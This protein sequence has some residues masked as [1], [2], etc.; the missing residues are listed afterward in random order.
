M[1]YLVAGRWGYSTQCPGSGN[2]LEAKPNKFGGNGNTVTIEE[3]SQIAN[4][5]LNQNKRGEAYSFIFNCGLPTKE[6]NILIH[7]Y[8]G[9]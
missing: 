1:C 3:I 6:I 8:F 9:S 2:W 7:Y 5:L 4:N